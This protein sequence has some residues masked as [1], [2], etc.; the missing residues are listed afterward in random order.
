M[1][2]TGTARLFGMLVLAAALAAGCGEAQAP[3]GVTV[4]EFR[5]TR[6]DE[7]QVVTGTLVNPSDRPLDGVAVEVAL[8][9]QPVEP[10][11]RPVETV[12]VER[13]DR[14]DEMGVGGAG[15][16]LGYE[17]GGGGDLPERALGGVPVV[18]AA[19]P[20]SE[21]VSVGQRRVEE[22]VVFGLDP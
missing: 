10:G 5:L 1:H 4:E 9:D 13:H 19:D 15:H 14:T 22:P 2:R 3:S 21:R 7:A 8:S 17:L 16:E 12:R 6:E 11:V 20:E 18:V